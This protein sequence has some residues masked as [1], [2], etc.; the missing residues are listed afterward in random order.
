[1]LLSPDLAEYVLDDVVQLDAVPEP[2][3]TFV[4]WSG[5]LAGAE[6]PALL[7]VTGAMRVTATFATADQVPALGPAG[8]A[9]A[10]ALL[11]ATAVRSLRRRAA[12]RDLR[13]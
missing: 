3:S 1:V 12:R 2:G 7:T 6:D 13:Y 5:D 10:A 8:L 4:G 11:G 9:L